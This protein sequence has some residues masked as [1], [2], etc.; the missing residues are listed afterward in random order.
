MKLLAALL[1]SLLA[2]LS[3]CAPYP[4]YVSQVPVPL[5]VVAVDP[6]WQRECAQIRLDI[7]RQQRIA[8]TSGIMATAL[9]EGAVRLNTSNVISGLE[10]RAALEGCPL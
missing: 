10:E 4:V 2:V 5:A 3:A 6:A 9:V 8:A 1:C 7:A